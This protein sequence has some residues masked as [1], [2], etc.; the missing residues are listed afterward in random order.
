[1]SLTAVLA[2]CG[3]GETA[4]LP[5]D[6]VYLDVRTAEEYDAGHVEG[7]RNIDFYAA[8]FADQLA[9]LPKDDQYVVYCQSGNRSGQAK[10]LMD[11][12][13]FTD[14]IDGGAYADLR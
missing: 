9:E 14:V 10:A 6:A 1:M 8:D 13:G 4:E 5:T 11:E 3:T 12:M 7:A 2:A